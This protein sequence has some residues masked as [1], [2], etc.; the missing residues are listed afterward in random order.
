MKN[1]ISHTRHLPTAPIIHMR[2]GEGGEVSRVDCLTNAVETYPTPRHRAKNSQ[3]KM[4]F[5]I[6][7]LRERK[8]SCR[9]HIRSQFRQKV[10]TFSLAPSARVKFVL[11]IL[12]LLARDT[13]SVYVSGQVV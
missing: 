10:T 3:A 6:F 1:D 4:N 2:M 12:C 5:S 11:P 7:P 9:D 13:F 8:H